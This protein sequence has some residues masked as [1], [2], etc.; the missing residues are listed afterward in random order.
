MLKTGTKLKKKKK[1]NTKIE[2]TFCFHLFRV[3]L[4]N[5]KRAIKSG[6]KCKQEVLVPTSTGLF[7]FQGI[8]S[9]FTRK[10]YEWEKAKGITPES[11]TF[12]LL[13]PDYNGPKIQRNVKPPIAGNI[14]FWIQFQEFWFFLQI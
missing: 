3:R 5:M 12:A 1:I 7:R 6:R 9:K 8:S 14:I 4:Q 13:D 2:L 10:L 11:S